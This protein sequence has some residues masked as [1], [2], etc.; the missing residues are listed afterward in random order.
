MTDSWVWPY[1]LDGDS[2]VTMAVSGIGPETAIKPAG[3]QVGERAF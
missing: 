1:R 3:Q 2:F